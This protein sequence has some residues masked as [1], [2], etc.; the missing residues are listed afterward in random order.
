VASSFVFSEQVSEPLR[1]IS[2]ASQ[3]HY[4]SNGYQSALP[5]FSQS[6][7]DDVV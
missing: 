5:P 3:F 7:L 1:E 6:L 4:F 2:L